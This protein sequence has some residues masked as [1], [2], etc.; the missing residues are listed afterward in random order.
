[1]DGERDAPGIAQEIVQIRQVAFQRERDATANGE[2][3]GAIGGN[4]FGG[5][6][7]ARGRVGG[8]GGGDQ[9][10]RAGEGEIGRDLGGAGDHA[11]CYGEEFDSGGG[12]QD[13]VG[14]GEGLEKGEGGWGKFGIE[15]RGS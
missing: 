13:L 7:D 6:E 15:R 14:V 11:A 9:V 5:C 4:A 3:E 10:G 1:M 12:D 2:P 8:G